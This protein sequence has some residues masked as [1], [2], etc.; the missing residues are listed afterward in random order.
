[1]NRNFE[2]L[3]Y[4]DTIIVGASSVLVVQFLDLT[5]LFKRTLKCES[6]AFAICHFEFSWVYDIAAVNYVMLCHKPTL[7]T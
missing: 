7:G 5:F 6:N 4:F 2:S 1:M 3:I